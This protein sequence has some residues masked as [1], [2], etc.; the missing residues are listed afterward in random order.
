MSDA[1][2]LRTVRLA[3]IRRAKS[4]EAWR[5]AIREAHAYG[6]SL[7]EIAKVAG[8]TNPRVHQIVRDQ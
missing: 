1:R 7:R 6:C 3:T 8:V 5:K 4:D 2:A